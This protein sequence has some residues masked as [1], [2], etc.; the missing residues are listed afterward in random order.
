MF[1]DASY[2]ALHGGAALV[3]PDDRAVLRVTGGDRATW[4]QGLLT[5]DVAALAPG[6]GC[7]AAWLT[8]QG[9]MITDM[10]VL[11][12]GDAIWLDVPGALAASL[13]AK[14][15]G[16]VFAED[17]AVAAAG[18]TL[19]AI[20]VHGPAAAPVFAAAFAGV[21][22]AADLQ[23]WAVYQHAE[24]PLP[25][26]P[27]RVVH[28]ETFGVPGYE[29]RADASRLPALAAAL[30]SAGAVSAP[31][32]VAELA[33]IEAGRPRFLVD[34]DEHTIPLEAGIEDE[35]IS[36][37][38]GCYVGQEVIVRVMHRGGGRV[39]KKLAGLAFDGTHAPRAGAVVRAGGRDIGAVTSAALSPMLGHAIA[40]AYV[41]RDF[42]EPGTRVDVVDGDATLAAVVHVT[43]F[44]GK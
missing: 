4:L 8:P 15:D 23:D 41:H 10:T 7:Y 29:I 12:T 28:V 40:L 39:A 32:D 35:A 21:V 38:K 17:V 13:A 24:L 20:G 14:L 34:M 5:N 19:A 6:R 3:E 9:R 16:M 42:V 2:K 31:R 25:D 36:F 37:T 27:A 18:D 22:A 33:R 44:V 11:E 30:R 1:N 43:P 26:G